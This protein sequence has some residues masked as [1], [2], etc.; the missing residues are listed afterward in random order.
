MAVRTIPTWLLTLAMAVV[1]AGGC[2]DAAEQI[3]PQIHD[4]AEPWQAAPFLVDPTIVAAAERV[5]RDPDP[6]M[7]PDPTMQLVLADTRGGNFAYLMFAN[8]INDGECSVERQADGSFIARGG[9]GSMGGLRAALPANG[10]EF[11]GTGSQSGSGGPGQPEDTKSYTTGRVGAAIA[12]VEVVLSDGSSLRATVANGWFAAWWP[13]A[14]TANLVRGYDRSG[15]VI[16]TG[17]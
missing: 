3:P 15:S 1:V 13:T 8:G 17:P 11:G 14:A 2:D 12:T 10:L 9:G 6:G 5:C 16:A 4:L 7:L